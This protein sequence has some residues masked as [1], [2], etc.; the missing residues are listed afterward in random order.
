MRAE[1]ALFHRRA[2]TPRLQL[3][4]L[5]VFPATRRGFIVGSPTNFDQPDISSVFTREQSLGRIYKVTARRDG[6]GTVSFFFPFLDPPR[7]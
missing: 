2:F 7:E 6:V 5:F 1:V 3:T 4:L